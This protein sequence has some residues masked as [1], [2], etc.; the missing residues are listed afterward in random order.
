[1]KRTDTEL[2]RMAALDPDLSRRVAILQTIP[3][4]G[5]VTAVTLIIDMPELGEL[6]GKHAARAGPDQLE[7]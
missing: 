5:E 4:V 1:M 6:E 3:G 2:A 7:A